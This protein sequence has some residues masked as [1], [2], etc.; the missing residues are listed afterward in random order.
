MRN[1]EL[2]MKGFCGAG[3]KQSELFRSFL[4]LRHWSFRIPPPLVS[5]PAWIKPESMMKS[6]PARSAAARTAVRTD[7]IFF[8]VQFPF[9]VVSEVGEEF[10]FTR[11]GFSRI[12]FKGTL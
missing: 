3:A 7:K 8:I 11:R 10:F 9:F 5:N 4:I 6:A 2:G 1:E 12:V